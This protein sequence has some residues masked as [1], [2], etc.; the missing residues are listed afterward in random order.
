MKKR[1]FKEELDMSMASVKLSEE[2]RR[3]ILSRAQGKHR[4]KRIGKVALAAVLAGA[5]TFGA[6][7][8]VP[9]LREILGRALGDFEPASQVIT[10]AQDEDNGIV[11]RAVSALSDRSYAK[12]YLEVQDTTGDRLGENTQL[13]TAQG[14]MGWH[15]E[16]PNDGMMVVGQEFLGYDPETKTALLELTAGGGTELERTSAHL[17]V[18]G[19]RG[20]VRDVNLPLPQEWMTAEELQVETA[21]GKN[22]LMPEQTP[23]ALEGTQDLRVSSMGFGSD[24]WFHL[25]VALS[26]N[27]KLDDLAL[28]TTLRGTAGGDD[29][30]Y[31]QEC[32]E[33]IFTKNGQAYYDIAIRGAAPDQW[34]SVYPDSLYGT[35]NTKDAVEGQWELDIALEHQEQVVYQAGTV[36]GETRVT[37]VTASTFAITVETENEGSVAFG[38][39]EQYATLKD[40]THLEL[41]SEN[42]LMSGW[43][44][45]ALTGTPAGSIDQWMLA[46]PIDPAQLESVTLGGVTVPLTPV[47]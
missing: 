27:V 41:T 43:H 24:G 23:H 4:P 21:E 40:G 38:T 26:E 12:I 30:A 10:G 16:L 2:R 3:A 8:A 13:R 7:A 42:L 17:T 15:L 20:G 37:Q 19:V 34:A 1:D 11:V 28:L 5:V 45:Q 14:T 18:Y 32:T 9:S 46:E 36:I 39:R 22:V 25:Q 6:L 33:T 44:G 35:F 31:N 47:P 29:M